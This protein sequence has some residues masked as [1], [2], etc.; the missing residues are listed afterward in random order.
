MVKKLYQGPIELPIQNIYGKLTLTHHISYKH[1]ETI[2]PKHQ[3]FGA[4]REQGAGASEQE[5]FGGAGAE[6]RAREFD[7]APAPYFFCNKALV[8]FIKNISQWN[9]F[10]FKRRFGF[11]H[12]I[13]AQ[14]LLKNVV[15]FRKII[16]IICILIKKAELYFLFS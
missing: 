4:E 15:F 8:F 10:L 3:G 13:L 9:S 14:C 7:S 2:E 6:Q 12:T 1:I 11:G 16:C 5:N